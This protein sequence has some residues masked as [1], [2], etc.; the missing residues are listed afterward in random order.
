ML[1]AG[2]VPRPGQLG[3]MKLHVLRR[4]ST[5]CTF[6]LSKDDLLEVLSYLLN[7]FP[8]HALWCNMVCHFDIVWTT[9]LPEKYAVGSIGVLASFK[10]PILKSHDFRVGVPH[11]R[12]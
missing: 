7:S 6:P 11:G 3:F 2:R 10:G 12:G 9:V 8:L 5:L 1:Q 4:G